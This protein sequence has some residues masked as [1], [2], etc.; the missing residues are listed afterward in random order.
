MSDFSDRYFEFCKEQDEK[1]ENIKRAKLRVLAKAFAVYKV[2][3]IIEDST[4]R[5]SVNSILGSLT[6]G[7]PCIVYAGSE[8]TKKNKPKKSGVTGYIF[9][10]ENHKGVTLITKSPN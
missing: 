6:L 5:I 10:D 7:I 3:D 8:L 9:T 2:G 1:C 4:K